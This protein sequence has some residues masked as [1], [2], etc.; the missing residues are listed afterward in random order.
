MKFRPYPEY[1]K[2]GMQWLGDIPVH[3]EVHRL[4]HSVQFCL[5][6]AWGDEPDGTN[7]FPCV[8]VADFNRENFRVGGIIPTIR[9]IA[10]NEQ[11]QRILHS[12]DL[13]L[14]KSGGGDKRPVGVVM[15]FNGK[16][17]AVCSNFI[18]RMPVRQGF[19]SSFL[20]F[21]HSTLY[22]VGLN[23]KSIK[24]TTGIQNLDSSTYLAE[25]VA[26][27]PL[28]EQDSIAR[29]L[30][31]ATAKIDGAIAAKEKVIALLS[32]QKK[33]IVHRAITRGLDSSAALKPS[34][35]PWLGDIPKHWELRRLSSCISEMESGGREQ[36]ESESPDGIPNL[37]GEH[38]GFD[39][40]IISENMRYVSV[41]YF[42]NMKKGVVRRG[43]ILLVKDG[44]T[45]GKAAF[46]REI[47]FPKCSVNEHVAIIRAEK[48]CLPEFLFCVIVSPGM[49]SVI[50]RE[51]S[52]SAQPGLNASFAKNIIFV[53]PPISEQDSIAQYLNDKTAKIAA[54]AECARRE[55]ALLREYRARLI[56]DAVTGKIDVRGITLK[57]DKKRI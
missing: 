38:I 50:W 3:W 40:Q 37:G 25:S 20:T 15:L 11:K 35:V 22:A 10:P 46:M 21:Q 26:F 29:F 54:A 24:Q 8:R 16:T 51:T 32:E 30:D 53:L 14:E 7:D 5:N 47:P 56:A 57:N 19:D 18:A 49:Q 31:W 2:S 52:G 39:G 45:I 1:K 17:P 42:N 28:A 12:G 23:I 41:P 36:S 27:P 44:A 48:E 4:R 33:A 6:G 13:L 34:G 43:D 55:I 9:S